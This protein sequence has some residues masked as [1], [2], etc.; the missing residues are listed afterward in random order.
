M[1]R[2]NNRNTRNTSS[3]VSTEQLCKSVAAFKDSL[4]LPTAEIRRI[5]RETKDQSRSPLWFSVRR[6]RITASYFGEIFKHLPTTL[7]HLVLCIIDPKPFNCA[8]T[9]WGKIHEAC[10]LEEYQKHHPAEVTL[11]W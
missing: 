5:E 4:K 7:H 3:C 9:E 2:G 1:D 6:Y 8:A 10:A 11:T